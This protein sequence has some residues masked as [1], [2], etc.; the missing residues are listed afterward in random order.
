L[1]EKILNSTFFKWLKFKTQETSVGEDVEKEGPLCA[2]GGN[3]NWCG[4]CGRQYFLKK[5]KI[6]LSYNP[7]IALLGIYPK[8]L[9]TLI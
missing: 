3:A 1:K 7:G 2:V 6:E 8:N 9:K 4:H 5:L